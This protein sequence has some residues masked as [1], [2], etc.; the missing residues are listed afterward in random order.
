[1]NFEREALK[2]VVLLA[3]EAAATFV[4]GAMEF[5]DN[6]PGVGWFGIAVAHVFAVVA[7]YLYG[8]RAEELNANEECIAALLEMRARRAAHMIDGRC[9]CEGADVKPC[10]VAP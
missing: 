2:A 7:G 1:M 3:L 5:V 10:E 9:L 8:L 4:L 6:R